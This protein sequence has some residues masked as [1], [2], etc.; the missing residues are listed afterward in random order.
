[1]MAF[2]D[3]DTAATFILLDM[4]QGGRFVGV[5]SVMVE[6]PQGFMRNKVAP[7]YWICNVFVKKNRRKDGCGSRL[8]ARAEEHIAAQGAKEAHL[9]CEEHLVAFYGAR[10]WIRNGDVGIKPGAFRMKKVL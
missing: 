6:E 5:V 8:L 9:W 10:G 1:M 7:E 3:H 2:L 4:A